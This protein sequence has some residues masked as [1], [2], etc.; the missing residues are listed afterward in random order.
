MKKILL[1]GLLLTLLANCSAVMEPEPIY[2]APG[3][4]QDQGDYTLL[5][6]SEAQGNVAVYTIPGNRRVGTID[7]SDN[8]LTLEPVTTKTRGFKLRPTAEQP[9]RTPVEQIHGNHWS[10]YLGP[11]PRSWDRDVL[12]LRPENNGCDS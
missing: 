4:E 3:N 2:R 7:A 1:C 11:F 9:V 5:V 8:C 6:N 12:S 10:I